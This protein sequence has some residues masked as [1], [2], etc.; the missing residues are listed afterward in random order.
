VKGTPGAPRRFVKVAVAALL[1]AAP[2]H[3]QTDVTLRG[4]VDVGSQSFAAQRSFDAVLGGTRGPVFGGGVEVV[5][6]QQIFVSLRASRFRR[7][8]QR[9]FAFNNELF[10]LGIPVT[11]TIA[12]VELI[13]G[14]RFNY[15]SRLVPYAGAGVGWHRYDETS[16]FADANENVTDRFTGFHV[17]GGTELRIA[18]W[19]GTAFDVEWATVP[20]A[21]GDHPNSVSREFRESNLGG[22]TVRV[23]LI[24]GR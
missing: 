11:V 13:G 10:N 24:V 8:G 1:F 6:P 9:V 5:L 17:L 7:T 2:A 4:F 18:R 3:A 14:Y 15:R 16:E 22:V 20:H 21:I 19:I 23:K 12:P